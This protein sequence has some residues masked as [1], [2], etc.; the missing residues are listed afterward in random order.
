MG[1]V[2]LRRAYRARCQNYTYAEACWSQDMGCWIDTHVRTFEFIGGLPELVVPDNIRTGISRACRYA[3]SDQGVPAPAQR[4]ASVIAPKK[5]GNRRQDRQR[6]P[7]DIL[8][9]HNLGDAPHS[10]SSDSL[11]STCLP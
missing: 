4:F 9:N 8:Q 2:L 11:R 10:I 6:L 5:K 3:A 1:Q 7:K